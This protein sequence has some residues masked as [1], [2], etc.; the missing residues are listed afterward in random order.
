MTLEEATKL[1]IAAGVAYY[2]A[3]GAPNIDGIAARVLTRARLMIAADAYG[4]AVR[5]ANVPTETPRKA[6]PS[7][8]E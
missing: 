2:E 3:Q 5:E 7:A 6:S 1:F 8:E 4:L